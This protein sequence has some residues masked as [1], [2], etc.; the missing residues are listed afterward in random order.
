M[1]KAAQLVRSKAETKPRQPKS[2]ELLPEYRETSYKPG[3]GRKIIVNTFVNKK[4]MN[5]ILHK[6]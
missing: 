5:T 4:E 1:C 2:T 3:I 6:L